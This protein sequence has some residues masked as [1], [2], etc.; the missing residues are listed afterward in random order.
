MKTA[1][2][3]LTARLGLSVSA[4]V[5]SAVCSVLFPSLYIELQGLPGKY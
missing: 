5:L 4:R 2:D 1:V 3:A